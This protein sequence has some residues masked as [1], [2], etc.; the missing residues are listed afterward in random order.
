MAKK[1][2]RVEIIGDMLQAILNRKG[3]IK[4][5]HL[6]YKANL[7][8]EQLRSYLE[9]LVNKEFVEKVATPEHYTYVTITDKGCKFVQKWQ[10]MKQFEKSFGL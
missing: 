4:P 1:R 8:H 3:K 7:S 6:M 9:E 2:D 5:T 10:E